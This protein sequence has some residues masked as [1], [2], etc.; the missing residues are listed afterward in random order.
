MPHPVPRLYLISDRRLAGGIAG[1]LDTLC[2]IAAALPPGTLAVQVREKDL[3]PR[4]IVAL[5][6]AAVECLAPWGVPVLVND[7]FDLAKASGAAG[8]HL[9]SSGL[10]PAEVRGAYDGIV[11]VSTHS[12]AELSRL[13]PANVDFAAF[14]PIFDTPSKRPYG[15]PLGVEALRHAVRVS[16]VPVVA[17]GGIRLDNAGLLSGSGAAGIATISAVL[18]APDPAEA[19]CRMADAAVDARSH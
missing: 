13:H 7:R 2:R 11:A 19:A 5:S 18:A 16:G 3:G 10:D 6:R 17:L 9:S 4:D 12:A 1:M 15:P 14:G 8:V